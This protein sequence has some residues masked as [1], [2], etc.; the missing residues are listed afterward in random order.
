[1]RYS[2]G[3][4]VRSGDFRASI[5]ADPEIGAYLTAEQ[6]GEAFSLDRQLRNVDRIFERVFGNEFNEKPC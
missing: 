3:T 4:P 5:E 1:I 6:I 2:D